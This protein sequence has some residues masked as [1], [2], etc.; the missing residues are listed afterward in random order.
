VSDSGGTAD[1]STQTLTIVIEGAAVGA[2]SAAILAPAGGQT[3]ALGESVATS[4]TCADAAGAPG[5]ASC[6]DSSG[7][8]S[9]GSLDTAT[10][11]AHTYTVTALSLDGE[12]GTTTIEYTVAS[13]STGP[14]GG[15][16]GTGGS[17]S[18]SMSAGGS[19]SSTPSP[20][21]A[22]TGANGVRPVATPTAARKLARAIKGCKKLKK[23][24]R[25]RCIAAAKRR[26]APAKGK[27]HKPV[28]GSVFA[29]LHPDSDLE[30][31]LASRSPT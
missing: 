2:P 20:S 12:H 30:E 16:G 1:A 8:A 17:T 7:K 11:G 21:T 15:G 29:Q 31:F 23:N 19:S 25:A 24:K 3:Y 4:F 18:S 14:G 13:P 6:T 27:P 26:Y 28:R 22:S 10:P 5:V 9:P